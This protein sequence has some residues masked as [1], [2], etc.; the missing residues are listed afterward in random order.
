MLST[1]IIGN[2]METKKTTKKKIDN[3]VLPIPMIGK[4]LGRYEGKTFYIAEHEQGVLFH[5]YNSMDLIVRKSQISTYGTLTDIVRNGKL[6]EQDENTKEEFI[7]YMSAVTYLLTLPIYVFSDAD[8][9][10]QMAKKCVEYHR[11]II[12]EKEEELKEPTLE[13][14]ERDGLFQNAIEGLEEIKKNVQAIKEMEN[15]TK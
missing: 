4:E 6:Q 3:K 9:M 15:D 7:T 11:E 14:M 12:Q 5:V 2:N 13:D 1:I 10:F 8:F